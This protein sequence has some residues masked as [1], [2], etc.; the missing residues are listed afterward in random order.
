[1]VA[2]A[3]A[4]SL[5]LLAPGDVDLDLSVRAEGRS[6]TVAPDG[7]APQTLVSVE[8]TPRATLSVSGP[9]LRLSASYAPE[10][11]DADVGTSFGLH[12]LHRAQLQLA[13]RSPGTWRLT[14]TAAGARGTTDLLSEARADLSAAQPIA[15]LLPVEY[16]AGSATFAAVGTPDRR[17][18]LT[19]AT[20]AFFS[21]G[22]DA[23]SR[24]LL[25]IERGVLAEG[26]LAWNATRRDV[27]S[28]RLQ[29]RASR[30]E[31]ADDTAA[32]AILSGAWRHRFD[33]AWEG[34]VATGLA[35]TYSAAPGSSTLREVLPVGEAAL[36]FAAT[37]PA[38]VD[39][40]LSASA[41]P[42]IDRASG[43]VDERIGAGASAGWQ[44]WDGWTLSAQ[45]EIA[46][47]ARRG[48]DRE[49]SSAASTALAWTVT[50]GV[51]F[52]VG[53][54]ALRQRAVP[55]LAIP[56]FTDY[57]TY[58]A[59]SYEPARRARAPSPDGATPGD[60]PGE[61]QRVDGGG[62]PVQ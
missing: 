61:V 30:F 37:R 42:F 48:L 59:A 9:D 19:L 12:V 25:P 1:M 43:R 32:F 11:R 34:R 57:E 62:L 28:A 18:V 4:L 6:R 31:Q 53:V 47:Y 49:A 54:I 13:E 23:R 14:A 36:S 3:L 50:R 20:Q 35:A 5:V 17:T 10:L 60:P 38:R 21:G 15:T 22:G 2:S 52:S 26:S 56:G 33:P 55:A 27:L 46:A 8:T 51:V 58:A 41:A 39:A 7:A 45:L 16:Q 40:A 44:P 29:G 24:A